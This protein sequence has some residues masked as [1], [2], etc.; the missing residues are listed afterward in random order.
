MGNGIENRQLFQAIF[1]SSVEGILVMDDEGNL[2]KVNPALKKIFGY[3]TGELL[4]LKVEA[5]IP[6]KFREAHGRLRKKYVKRPEA[7]SM[8][9]GM[10][11]LGLRKDGSQIPVEVSLSPTAIDGRQ[12]VIAFVVDITE[13]SNVM[14]ALVSSERRMAEVQRIAHVGSW[15]RDLQTG[16]RDFSDEFY[17]IC[18]LDPG[19][20]QLNAKTV[21][22]FI[23]PD[24]RDKALRAVDNAIKS[25]NPYS[26]EKRIVRADGCIRY[27][28]TKGRVTY[29]RN[30]EPKH[31]M[32]TMQDVTDLKKAMHE[33]YE[34]DRKFSTLIGNLPGIVYRCKNDKNWTMEFISDGCYSVTGY[35]AAEF[36]DNGDVN[37]GKIVHPK[38]RDL[39]LDE[40]WKATSKKTTYEI[41]YRIITADKEI[42]W[43][44]EQGVGIPDVN[45]QITMLE[46]FMQDITKQKQ[47]IKELKKE[48]ETTQRY[49]DTAASMFLVINKKGEIISIN[50][51][52][53]EILGY[54]PN[55]ILGKNWFDH[56]IPERRKKQVSDI[57]DVLMQDD[58]KP[59]EFIEEP[60]VTK[61]KKE[62]LIQWH[63][64][65]LK[66]ARGQPVA[67]LSSGS[68]VTQQKEIENALHIR[69][70]ALESAINGI[71]IADAQQKDQPIIYANTAFTKMTGYEKDE[72]IGRN[73]RFLQSDDRDQEEIKK[74][75]SAIDKGLACHVVLRNYRKDGSL[76][77]NEVAITP[78]HNEEGQ[79]THFIGLLNDVTD[80]KKEEV[81]KDQV[82]KGLEMIANQQPLNLIAEHILKTVEEQIENCKASI[83]IPDQK[84]GA[85]Y[86]LAVPGLMD[87]FSQGIRG[88]HTG[89][90]VDS[91]EATTFL[92]KEV[93]V[94]DIDNDPLCEDYRQLALQY[95]IKACWSIP[96]FSSED[97]AIGTF[98]I[99][100]AQPRGPEENE[101]ELLADVSKL[102]SIAIEKHQLYEHLRTTQQQL[103][104][105]ALHLEV[106]VEKRTL[107]L[108]GMVQKLVDA[109]ANLEDQIHET[110]AA[111][112]KARENQ[113]L[114][115][116][117]GRHFPNGIILVINQ[118]YEIVFLEGTEIEKLHISKEDFY[119]KKIF[120]GATGVMPELQN[121]R[122]KSFIQKTFKGAHE[123]FELEIQDNT[124]LANTVPLFGDKNQVNHVLFVLHNITKQKKVEH[125]ITKA[126][127]KER[128]LSELKSR[129]IS[130]ASHEFRTPLSAILTSANLISR[131]NEPGKEDKRIRNIDRI[132]SN[133]RTLVGILDDFL[134]LGKLEEG[135]VTLRP[136]KFDL[137]DFAR[138]TF[139]ELEAYKKEGQQIELKANRSSITVTLD[140][141]I[142]KNILLNLLSNALKYSP[143][144]K[145]VTLEIH[146]DSSGLALCVIDEGIGIPEEEQQNLFKR[147]YRARNVTNIQGTGLGLNI[148]KKYVELMDGA[149]TFSS[150]LSKGTTFKIYLP[151][152]LQNHEKDITY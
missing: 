64:A 123:S 8:G 106:K 1:E 20:K 37:W 142:I 26:Y 62:K 152:N 15:Y 73:C 24:D 136:E 31:I 11:I 13:R 27:V 101:K 43:I 59:V 32:G 141:Q 46:G 146:F 132:R 35:Q 63:N 119:G 145:T 147:F 104:D 4:N 148:V 58:M 55:E 57:F 102:A 88:I 78:V 29:D 2:I 7:R 117:I 135:K 75:R 130:M 28:I 93:I 97:R 21:M 42:K 81:Q 45:S 66:D 138:S 67:T 109:N 14:H 111:E 77:W 103:E 107:E 121:E 30:G 139:T 34:S 124:Y 129:F 51:K 72:V 84:E 115:V 36:Y 74:M 10:H 100:C 116:A 149:I 17:R 39:V 9:K 151:Q 19:D 83:L 79:L 53:C 48:K 52:G 61:E 56:F 143:K 120:N 125:R 126:L 131:Q 110:K 144:S 12:L 33:V 87:E 137:L 112:A 92:K 80:R 118:E 25:G 99:Y 122:F 86:K 105:Y 108:N 91:G 89:V 3:D 23:H 49:L 6:V 44:W 113:A 85:L 82:R 50:R 94:T 127:E 71:L 133:V 150:K 5:L 54:P 98:A 114:F 95:G 68:D 140:R 60:V 65:V 96:I 40:I 70:R 41:S 16:E 38:D 134:S 69:N 22:Q 90:A 47:T 76:F 128:E 18:G